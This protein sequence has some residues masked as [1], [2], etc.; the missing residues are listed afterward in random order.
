MDRNGFTSVTPTL[1]GEIGELPMLDFNAG[2]VHRARDLMPRNG[3]R[4]PWKNNDR[5]TKDFVNLEFKHNK[6]SEL[7]FR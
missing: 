7:K 5:Y 1:T 4:N 6:Y 3:D 2:Y